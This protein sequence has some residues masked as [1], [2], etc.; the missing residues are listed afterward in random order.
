[1][2]ARSGRAA[3][4]EKELA[5]TLRE[6]PDKWA[7]IRDFTD[8][9]QRKAGPLAQQIRAGTRAA[10]RVNRDVEDGLF[11]AMSRKIS[12]TNVT[13]VYVRYATVDGD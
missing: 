4:E 5:Q 7:R 2:I 12:G 10:F 9:D 13:A 3:D 11:E 1:M 6:N 8:D